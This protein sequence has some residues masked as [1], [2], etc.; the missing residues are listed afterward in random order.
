MGRYNSRAQK[1]FVFKRAM[2]RKGDKGANPQETGHGARCI[3]VIYWSDGPDAITLRG[4][5]ACEPALRRKGNG[6]SLF[7]KPELHGCVQK[8]HGDGVGV[9]GGASRWVKGR[10]PSPGAP[11]C[12]ALFSED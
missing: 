11:D 1:A 5:V 6:E 10:H 2:P 9:G 8:N 4:K 3:K 7:P 12:M